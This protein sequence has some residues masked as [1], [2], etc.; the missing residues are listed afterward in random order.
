MGDFFGFTP[1]DAAQ[2]LMKTEGTILLNTDNAIK[3]IT[4]TTYIKSQRK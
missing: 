1:A 4:N 3:T 2:D